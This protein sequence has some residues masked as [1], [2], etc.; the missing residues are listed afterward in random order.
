MKL[1]IKKQIG[2]NSYGFTFD[3]KDLWEVLM[4]SQNI[5]I[6]DLRKCGLCDSNLLRL[7]AYETKEQKYQYI[8]VQCNACK[9]GLTL[10]KAK[11]TGAYFYRRDKDSGALDWQAYEERKPE[12]IAESNKSGVNWDE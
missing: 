5:S 10:G 9:A 4:E 12:T 8:K 3:G 7:F 2:E 11:A 6:Y 1:N